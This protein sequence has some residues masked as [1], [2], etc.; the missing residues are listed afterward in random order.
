[1]EHLEG[2]TKRAIEYNLTT[3]PD[4][5]KLNRKKNLLQARIWAR[6]LEKEEKALHAA[7]PESLEKVLKDKRLFLWQK[8]LQIYQYDDLK[9]FDLMAR[10][11]ELVGQHD[12]PPC[13]PELLKPASLTED[14]LRSSAIWRRKAALGRRMVVDPL[15]IDHS[16]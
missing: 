1:M 5:I 2:V 14:Q 9:V 3:S 7:F 12:T 6:M 8:L 4:L 10:G 16:Y 11:V 15:H 13:Y